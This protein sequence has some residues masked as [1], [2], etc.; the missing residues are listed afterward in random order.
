MKVTSKYL[1]SCN[2]MFTVFQGNSSRV[3]VIGVQHHV[4]YNTANALH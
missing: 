1:T 4:P 3:K 2:T